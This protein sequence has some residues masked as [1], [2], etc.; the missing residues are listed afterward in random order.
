MPRETIV[1]LPQ[2]AL[3]PALAGAKVTDGDTVTVTLAGK[4]RAAGTELHFELDRYAISVGAK[5][6]PRTATA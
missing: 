3:D 6:K 5:A 2:T 1:Y 4:V